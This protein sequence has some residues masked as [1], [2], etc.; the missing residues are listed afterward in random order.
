[1]LIINNN[2]ILL[3]ITFFIHINVNGLIFCNCAIL[4]ASSSCLFPH[5][6]YFGNFLASLRNWDSCETHMAKDRVAKAPL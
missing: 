1:M 5:F 4:H 6:I 2:K 3:Y